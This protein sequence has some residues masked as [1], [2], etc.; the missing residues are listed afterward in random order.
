V[1]ET[2]KGK[3]MRTTPYDAET[4]T[5]RIEPEVKERLRQVAGADDRT[6]SSFVR[7]IIDAALER[8]SKKKAA[9]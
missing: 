6:I 4:I 7:K 8:H 3:I 2:F 1:R 9:V 5:L